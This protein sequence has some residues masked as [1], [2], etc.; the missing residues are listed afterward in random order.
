VSSGGQDTVRVGCGSEEGAAL[1]CAAG[2]GVLWRAAG[3]LAGGGVFWFRG[4]QVRGPGVFS[5]V[6]P[7]LRAL[8]R[9]WGG[10][11][12]QRR[13]RG[14]AWRSGTRTMAANHCCK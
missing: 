10:W 1:A 11:A 12:R 9:G 14:T 7:C 4:G 8:G 3:A 2:C 13:G 6:L 5:S